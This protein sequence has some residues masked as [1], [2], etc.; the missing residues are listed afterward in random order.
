MAFLSEFK[1][2]YK[3]VH[4]ATSADNESILQFFATVVMDTE[5]L[6]LYYE[7][8]PNFFA[9]I[10]QQGLPSVTFL[11]KNKDDSIGGVATITTRSCWVN[12]AL[13][14]VGYSGDLRVSPQL[15]PRTRVQWRRMYAELIDRYHSWEDIG[16]VDYMYT[17][18]MGGNRDAT[19]ALLKPGANPA[20]HKIID[21]NSINIFA[22]ICSPVCRYL[23]HRRLKASGYDFSWATS[24]DFYDVKQFLYRENRQK[25]L[26]TGYTETG[27]GELERRLATWNGFGMDSFLLVRK[28]G[29]LVA[30]CA[31]WSNGDTRR[32]VIKKAPVPLRILGAV[33]PLFGARSIRVAN[34]LKTLYL[35]SL[36][37]NTAF[38]QEERVALLGLMVD[39]LFLGEQFKGYNLVSI[40]NDK[41]CDFTSGV[42][43]KGYLYTTQD[44]ALYQVLSGDE[45]K[46]K[47][48]LTT[49]ENEIVGFELAVS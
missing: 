46:A 3:D 28:A 6:Q 33:M 48:F 5:A 24:D 23:G 37:I 29:E 21:F 17:V 43:G 15:N 26:G 8:R 22:Q 16:H 31:P 41:T 49:A 40:F 2:K 30:C 1:E 12:G 13:K 44:A 34:E 38:A 36:E 4:L 27:E 7:R 35:T 18:I 9:F 14:R 25:Q 32:I 20:Y 19:R 10:G 39:F 47:R 11:F 45:V 42:K